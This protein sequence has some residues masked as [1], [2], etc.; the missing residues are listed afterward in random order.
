MINPI[1]FKLGPLSLHWYAVCIL[2]GLLLAVYLAAKE[3]PRKKMTS[4]DIIDFILIAFPLAII[5]ARI[6]YVAFEWSYYS[7]HLS[8]I[9]AI[10]NGGIAIYGGLI[11]G[12][13]VLFVYCYYK[14][15]NPIHFLDIAAPSVMLAQAI[16]RWGNFFNQ[17]A[18]GKAVS[19]LNYLPSFIRQQMFIDGS[20]RV[21]TFLYESMWNLIGFVIIMVWR[22][23]PRSLVD[24][25]IISFYLIWYGCG[26]LVIEGMR[27][28]SLMLLGIRVSQYVSVLLIIIAIVF[29]FK[30]HRQKGISYYQE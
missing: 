1:A 7:Q 17:E 12:A 5:G 29:I 15:L 2:V 9:F 20:Y 6:Y 8:D 30:R 10:W 11:T 28:D 25:D 22:R 3:A 13:I 4:D 24:G 21:P 18:Y 14:V 16:G 26:R 19:Q 27:T 23:K